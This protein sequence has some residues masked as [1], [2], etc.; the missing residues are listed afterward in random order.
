[1]QGS[2]PLHHRKFFRRSPTLR[3]ARARRPRPTARRAADGPRRRGADVPGP[4]SRRGTGGAAV[5]SP[6]F[7]YPMPAADPRTG[8][9]ESAPRGAQYHTGVPFAALPHDIA[10]DPRLT[11]TDLRVLATLLF[12]ARADFSCWP[13]D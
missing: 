2:V 10:A 13:S 9:G 6:T 3:P 12:F 11:P 5:N 1:M 4:D 7:R 8:R